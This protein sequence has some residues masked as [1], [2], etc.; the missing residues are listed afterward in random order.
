MNFEHNAQITTVGA[1]YPEQTLRA[2][3][4]LHLAP[5]QT[6]ADHSPS[7]RWCWDHNDHTTSTLLVDARPCM[8]RMICIV[9]EVAVDSLFPVLA[10]M[11][12]YERD[13]LI[14]EDLFEMSNTF[15]WD[16]QPDGMRRDTLL[17][18]KETTSR[19]IRITDNTDLE[20]QDRDARVRPT[21]SPHALK[22]NDLVVAFF[23]VHLEAPILA[24]PNINFNVRRL[25]LVHSCTDMEAGMTF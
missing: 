3:H 16:T 18:M 7:A 5:G 6:L 25:C 21:L 13:A 2:L 8:L 17:S 4:N 12:L 15:D 19:S 20:F 23:T 9:R 10:V 1:Y 11:P 24:P 14:C 22:R